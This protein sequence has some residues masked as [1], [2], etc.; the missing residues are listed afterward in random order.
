M[1]PPLSLSIFI[2]PQNSEKSYPQKTQKQHKNAQGHI[3]G[4]IWLPKSI[5]KTLY[6]EAFANTI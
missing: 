3:P 6:D 4:R 5:E 2:I 1:S